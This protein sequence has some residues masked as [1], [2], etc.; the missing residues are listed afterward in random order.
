M[1]KETDSGI[2]LIKHY[3]QDIAYF[4]Y[5]YIICLVILL[6][7][8]FLFN[9]YSSRLYEVKASI[10]P[11]QNDASSLLTSN[12]LFMGLK[13]LQS[14]RNLESG[15]S[16]FISFPTVS[17]TI[18]S[19]NLEIGYF[20]EKHHL[21]RQ[22]SELYL[23]SPYV[24]IM[25]K[26]HIQPIDVKLRVF[27]LSDTTFR[28]VIDQ[29]TVSLYNYLDNQIVIENVPL[30][31]DTICR[32]N[33]T[34]RGKTFKFSVSFNRDFYTRETN[35][36]DF[37]YFSFFHL[38]YLTKDYLKKLEVEPIS[39]KTSLIILKF[40]GRNIEK[41]VSFLNR[42]T[43]AI[44][45]ENLA[46]KN[47]IAL[48]TIKFIDSQISEISDSLVIS[49]SK[50]RN[51]R[52]ANQVMDLSFQ[53]KSLYEKL[54]QIE[55]ERANLQLQERYY[56]YIINNFKSSNDMSGV[57][58]PS[59][60]NVADPIMNQLITQ[61]LLLY[62]QRSGI[63]SNNAEKNLFLG[64]IDNKIK[65]QKQAIIETVTNNLNTLNLSL[66]ELNYRADK[67]SREISQLPRTELNMV[68]LQRKFDLSDVIYTYLL[69]KRSE[70]AITMASNYPDFEVIE[71]AREF[72]K[73]IIVPRP[74]LSYLLAIFFGLAIPT[75]FIFIRNF[76]N[77]KI[78]SIYDLESL[79]NQSGMGVIFNNNYKSEAVVL[80][81]PKSAIAESF[82]NLRSSL[83]LKLKS[84]KSKVI[85]ITSSQPKDGKSFISFNLAASIAIVGYKT[86][87]ID[88]DLRK[89]TLHEKFKEDN[90]SGISNFMVKNATVTEIIRNTSVENLSFIPAGPLLP[91]P[92]ELIESGVLDELMNF[93]KKEYDYIIVDTS[94]VG[95]VADATQLIRY[96]THILL[97]TRINYT[98]KDIL[99][100]V[101]K[102]FSSNR[103]TNYDAVL[104]SLPLDTS[105]YRHYTSY[106]LKK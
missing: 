11:V 41:I 33:E 35:M 57:V 73:K 39:P 98:R 85:V 43:D 65:V 25:D 56:N 42:Y 90:S 28:L 75:T 47:K 29:N 58:P 81:A 103:I 49:E 89:P 104:N 59:A 14:N 60:M 7:V 96:A 74:K 78:S 40:R 54:E 13:A 45:E 66:N 82:R 61:L 4:K 20:R 101:L 79:I 94:P 17:S 67:L 72:T 27:I 71:P 83:F 63:A 92:S 6:T 8:A 21:F 70:A 15:I 93:L 91:N 64:Q 46:K 32:F 38:D 87:I 34:I 99:E 100:H 106:Y 97:V 48:S 88:C 105:P 77:N 95:L 37:Y 18:S 12:D 51:Y 26:S 16:N 36:E 2:A 24:V 102:N 86:I 69:Q 31:V 84:E 53:G 23:R 68:G 5:F 3:L 55:T 1:T 52:S 10:G 50:L 30:K 22:V 44:L 76:F 80:E 19:M 62:S 9:K